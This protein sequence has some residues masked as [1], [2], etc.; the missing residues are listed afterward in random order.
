M[1]YCINQSG[2][3]SGYYAG[4]CLFQSSV[5]TRGKNDKDNVVSMVV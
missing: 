3:K 2:F 5:F 1:V 4:N